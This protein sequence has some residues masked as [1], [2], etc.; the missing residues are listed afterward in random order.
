MTPKQANEYVTDLIKKGED[1]Y[2]EMF[3]E[4][5]RADYNPDLYPFLVGYLQAAFKAHLSETNKIVLS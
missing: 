4:K 2:Y 1:S 5:S 3:P